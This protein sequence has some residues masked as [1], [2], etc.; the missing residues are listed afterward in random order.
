MLAGIWILQFFDPILKSVAIASSTLP[1][2]MAPLILQIETKGS[3]SIWSQTSE[4][5]FLLQSPVDNSLKLI[6]ELKI[7]P[8]EDT[9]KQIT[10]KVSILF[11]NS[12]IC[13]K[14]FLSNEFFVDSLPKGRTYVFDFL[15]KSG[16]F[17]TVVTDAASK[18][19]VE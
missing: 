12:V 13:S 15:I 18:F 19:R 14:S 6:P 9:I 5:G 16:G 10:S 4:I 8:D 17:D 3:F 2:Y 11:K 7:S 1:P